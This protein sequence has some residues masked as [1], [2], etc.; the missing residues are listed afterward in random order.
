MSVSI[1]EF[2]QSKKNYPLK[3][4]LSLIW[5]ERDDI[6]PILE[7]SGIIQDIKITK[8]RVEQDLQQKFV[9]VKFNVWEPYIDDKIAEFIL[10][11]TEDYSE[12]YTGTYLSPIDVTDRTYRKT[13]ILFNIYHVIIG[14]E[15]R[16]K[17]P[18]YD[19]DCCGYCFCEGEKI[20]LLIEPE[21]AAAA[22]ICAMKRANTDED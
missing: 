10:Y 8:V 14:D 19:E 1:G 18:V 22:A 17:F 5:R 9:I 21:G 15:S 16:K 20:D 4:N 2:L 12:I 7:V 6:P 13:R 11:M 3:C